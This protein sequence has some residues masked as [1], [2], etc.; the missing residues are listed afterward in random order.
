[1]NNPKTR[2][3]LLGTM[4]DLHKQPIGYDLACLQ[5]IVAELAPDLLCAEVT[6]E[7]WEQC[8]LSHSSVEIRESLAPTIAVTDT[9]LIP[10]APTP[11]QFSDFA[12]LHGWRYRLV[13]IFDRFFRWGQ[14]QAHNPDTVNGPW[15]GAFCHTVCMAMELLWS[16]EERAAWEKQNKELADNILHAIQRD[17][18]RRVLVAVQCQRLHHLVPLLRAYA[19]LFDIV[20]YQNL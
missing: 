9:V 12:P 13:K 7:A 20:G 3:A 11:Q 16:A 15:F 4:S 17:T 6:R 2:L 1:M 14:I 10:V 19:D 18:G 5:N 8:D